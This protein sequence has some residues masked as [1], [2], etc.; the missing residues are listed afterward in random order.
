V[1]LEIVAPG[2]TSYHVL[3]SD[4]VAEL[5]GCFSPVSCE[6]HIPL[7]SLV[8]RPLA[9]QLPGFN[10]QLTLAGAQLDAES[11]GRM[12]GDGKLRGTLGEAKGDA[13]GMGS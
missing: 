4:D 5:Q 10:T 12:F 8:P 3:D 6:A 7:T 2:G 11:N 13:Q 9:Q 1:E